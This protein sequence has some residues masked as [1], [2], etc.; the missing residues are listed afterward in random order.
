MLSHID[1][2]SMINGSE[3]VFIETDWTVFGSL[4]V[5]Q[6]LTL[7][8]APVAFDFL[9]TSMGDTITAASLNRWNNNHNNEYN[10]KQ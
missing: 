2:A 8:Q 6:I 10:L 9:L 4:L 5:V 3:Y 1:S 7:P